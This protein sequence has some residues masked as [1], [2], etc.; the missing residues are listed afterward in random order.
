VHVVTEEVLL[1]INA[2]FK[3]ARRMQGA[4]KVCERG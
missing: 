1:N 3:A 2:V 4:I